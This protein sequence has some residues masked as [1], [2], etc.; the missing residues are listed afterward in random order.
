MQRAH[1]QLQAANA[2]SV[3]R[4]E[5]T[6]QAANAAQAHVADALAMLDRLL[7]AV[8]LQSADDVKALQAMLD[9]LLT[10]MGPV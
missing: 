1:G 7:D 9:A 5:A 3:A 2:E 6:E 10:E 8:T 4:I